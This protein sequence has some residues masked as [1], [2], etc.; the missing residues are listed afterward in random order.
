MMIKNSALLC[1]LLLSTLLLSCKESNIDSTISKQEELVVEKSVAKKSAARKEVEHSARLDSIRL[2]KVLQEALKIAQ[3]HIQ[4]TTFSKE[5]TQTVDSAYNVSTKLTIGNPFSE[6]LRHLIIRRTSPGN[7][8]FNI[9]LID[10]NTLKPVIH[11]EQWAMT[12]VS[13]SIADINGDR[14]K[15]FIV[16][17][18]ASTGCCLK[19]FSSVY[20]FQPDKN[21][22]TDN[23]QFINPTF[24]AKEKIIRGVCYGHPGETELYKFAW[25]NNTIDTLEYISYEKNDKGIKTGKVTISNEM[26]PK[27]NDQIIKKR[28]TVPK[29]YHTI[30]GYDWFTGEILN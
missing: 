15:D 24:S 26:F 2:G 27:T 22:F 1:L 23:Y 9:Y 12:Y 5:F 20:L 14:H 30:Y 13:D 16:N 7:V 8:N 25:N 29:E 28:N 6:Q 10:E 21:T 4:A 3:Q 19:A 18:Y 17:W 11:H